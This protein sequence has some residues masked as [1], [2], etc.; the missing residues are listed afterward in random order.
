M[1]ID[2]S[3]KKETL[4]M[5]MINKRKM[6][7]KEQRKIASEIVLKE[8][9]NYS[10][11]KYFKNI[12][13]YYSLEEEINT[14]PIIKELINNSK[15]VY[16][17]KIQN[18]KSLSFYKIDDLTDVEF[19]NNLNIYEPKIEN[20]N[21]LNLEN[22]D[23]IFVPTVAYDINNYRLGF[24]Q[25][26]YDRTLNMYNGMKVGIAFKILEVE[27]IYPSLNDIRLDHIIAG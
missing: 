27:S 16:L 3:E 11:M 20:K 10:I 26:C 8:I 9:R 1:K 25:G 15:N 23:I 12:A 6:L 17:P 24:G 5:E 22:L 4:R 7:T 19:N 13:I 2:E 18:D 14:I 21:P